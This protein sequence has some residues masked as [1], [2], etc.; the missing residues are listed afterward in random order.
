MLPLA[1][2]LSCSP[3]ADINRHSRELPKGATVAG[4][5]FTVRVPRSGLYSSLK[6][7]K[8][9]DVILRPVKPSDNGLVYLVRQFAAR[10]AATPR[11]ALD[12]WN[13]IPRSR[14]VQV[15]LLKSAPTRFKGLP[16]MRADMELLRSG[17]F[18]VASA[19]VV[20]RSPGYLILIDR[21]S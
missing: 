8:P 5:G 10:G 11:E 4:N 18:Q 1:S 2:L 21:P 12:E 3:L 16:A 7:K 9:G 19:L 17:Y 20:K 14:G 13:K 6:D 15:I